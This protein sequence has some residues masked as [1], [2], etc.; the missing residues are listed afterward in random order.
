M[1]FDQITEWLLKSPLHVMISENTMIVY[2]KGRKSGKAYHVPIDYL[3][4]NDTLLTVSFKERTWWRN[5]RGGAE[6]TILLRGKLIPAHSQVVEDDQGVA[7]GLK[8]F[9]GKNPQA[10]KIFNIKLTAAGQPELESLQQAAKKRVIVRT[11]L[12]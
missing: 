7:E 4:I 11:F 10:A 6:V 9:I 5:L 2:F 1:W 8:E 3:R 12:R